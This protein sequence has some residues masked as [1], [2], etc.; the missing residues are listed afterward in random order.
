MNA[1]LDQRTLHL[2]LVHNRKKY[3]EMSEVE[4]VLACQN[5]DQL[6]FDH[7]VR[8]NERTVY[9]LLHQM[10][11]DW[12]DS[13][14]LA[15]EVFIRVWRSIRLLRNPRAFKKWLSHIVTNLFYDELRKRPKQ[16]VISI[17]E[18]FTNDSGDEGSAREI[19]DVSGMP[20]EILQRHQLSD[21]INK[22]IEDLPEHFRTTIIMRELQGL[23]YEEIASLTHTER[24]TVKSRIARARAKIQTTLTPFLKDCA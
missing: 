10:A 9:G 4:L 24:G 21:A 6:A 16:Q 11:P 12:R 20:D 13:R 15:Q 2:Q 23:S 8:R 3:E 17:D 7:L 14:D 5:R 22:A 1:S 19:A 18:P